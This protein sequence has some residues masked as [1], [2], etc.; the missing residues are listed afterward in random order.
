MLR[1][2][3]TPMF[4]N[5]C[6]FVKNPERYRKHR[7]NKKKRLTVQD[8]VSSGFDSLVDFSP[9]E[10]KRICFLGPGLLEQSVS[11]LL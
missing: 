10:S 4:V 1:F 6:N 8:R 7:K 9:V 2:R 11:K 5:F 3:K